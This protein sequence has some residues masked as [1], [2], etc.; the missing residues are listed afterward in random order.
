MLS[1]FLRKTSLQMYCNIMYCIVLGFH[2]LLNKEN[3]QKPFLKAIRMWI[4][5]KSCA[6]LLHIPLNFQRF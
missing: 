5:W 4:N 3:P 2:F 6:H 1:E